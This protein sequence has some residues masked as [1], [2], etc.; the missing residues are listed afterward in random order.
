MLFG[1]QALGGAIGPLLGGMVA[2]RF[3][4]LAAFYFLAATIAVANIFIIGVR[5]PG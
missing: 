4:L 2:A 1:A 5:R 3:G